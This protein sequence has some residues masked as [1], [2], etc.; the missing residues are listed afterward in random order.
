MTCLFFDRI[1]DLRAKMGDW[2]AQGQRIALVPTL[3][4]L[5]GGHQSLMEVAMKM[6]DRVVVSIFVNPMQFGLGE[7]YQNYPRTMEEDQ[8]RLRSVGV[9]VLFAPLLVEVYPNGYE[10]TTHVEVPVLSESLCGAVR[11]G[12]FRGVATVVC[13]LFNMVHPDFAVFGEKDW[14]QLTVIRRMVEDLALPVEIIG[15]PTVREADGLAQSSRNVYLS[16]G[17]RLVAPA[18]HQIMVEAAAK[19]RDGNRGYR[20]IEQAALDTLTEAGFRP[21]Y[22]AVRRADL[23][24]EPTA[25]TALADLRILAA[26]WLGKARLIDNIS[27]LAPPR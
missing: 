1:S 20:M 3:G 18:L 6:A 13:K 17:D 22:F 2:R 25:D 21:D 14:Q 15:A 11:P 19:L 10:N 27:V 8:E 12:H 4:N 26:A 23:L 5:H 9:D 7:D 16:S 24:T